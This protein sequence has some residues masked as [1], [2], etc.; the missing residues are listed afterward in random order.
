MCVSTKTELIGK[1]KLYPDDS[2]SHIAMQGSKFFPHIVHGVARVWEFQTFLH[3]LVR[4]VE[5]DLGPGPQ[6][7]SLSAPLNEF[8]FINLT[9][10]LILE[11]VK[12][13]IISM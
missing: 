6:A 3:C 12:K 1:D 2:K 8:L 11:T 9:R 10:P 5:R 7:C 4:A 13:H